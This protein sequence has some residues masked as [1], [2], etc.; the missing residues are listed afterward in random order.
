MNRRSRGVPGRVV[1]YGV[2]LTLVLILI[3]PFIWITLTAF[4]TSFEVNAFPPKLFPSRISLD[5]FRGL[6]EEYSFGSHFLNSSIIAFGTTVV[7]LFIGS[8]AGYSIARLGFPG[9][10]IL[11]LL[12]LGSLMLPAVVIIIP[13]YRILQTI[14]L[15][16]THIGLILL[17]CTYCVPLVVWMMQGYFMTIPSALEESARIDGCSYLGAFFRIVVPLS[18]PG[19]AAAGIFIFL[20]VWNEFLFALIFTSTRAKTLTVVISEFIGIFEIP[21]NRLSA[22]AVVTALPV[23]LF[24]LFFQ[25]QLVAGLTKGAVK[26]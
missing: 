2:M 19:I 11:L 8:F 12:L 16:D 15:I 9:A 26:E 5:S 10:R 24:M 1:F 22:A 21:W 20:V 13:L 4:K 7:S 23:L 6:F 18:A 3:F 25:K 17:N 14:G